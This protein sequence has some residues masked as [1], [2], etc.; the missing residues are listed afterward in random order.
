MF[1]FSEGLGEFYIHVTEQR[2]WLSRLRIE[3]L[4]FESC[5]DCCV[6]C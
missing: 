1:N 6:L 4:R 2:I 5:F 3:G